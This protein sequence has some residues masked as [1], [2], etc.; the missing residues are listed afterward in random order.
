MTEKGI[1]AL[2]VSLKRG[3]LWI[4]LLLCA[5]SVSAQSGLYLPTDKPVRNM[6]KAL[7]NPEAFHL[8][9]CLRGEETSY[10]EADLDLLDSVYAIAFAVEN[11][12]LYTMSIEGY[13]GDDEQVTQQRMDAVYRYFAMRCHAQFPIRY[14]RNPIRCSCK[15]DTVEVL[16]FEVPVATAAYNYS[17]LPESRRLLNKSIDLKNSVL[18][19]FRNNPDECVGS[20]R[21]CYIPTEDSTVY[22]YYASLLLSKGSV[23][24]VE[25]TKD[26]CPNGLNIKIDDYLDYR[27]IVERYHLIPHR[28]QILAMAG[29]IVVS[30]QW[31]VVSD[32]C[33]EPQKDS[34][35]VRIPVTQEQ[36]DAKLKFFAKVRTSYGLEYKQLPTRKMP[37]KGALALQAPVNITQ[38]DTIYVGKRIQE[39]EVSKYFYEVDS[40]TEAAS[41][42]I[43]NRFY[44]ASRPG[45]DGRPELKKA[46]RQLFRIIPDQ[47]EEDLPSEKMRTPKGEEIIE[48]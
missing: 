45:K 7:V 13:G 3:I 33:T 36:L 16:R 46:L 17:E 21:G 14:A 40:P 18:V 37:G 26:T 27:Y 9:L 19:T 23:Y 1:N 41:F 48:D 5:G 4:L 11:P 47:E 10:S 31:P 20:A 32:S 24:S 15:G 38:L 22:G 8:L 44:V 6:Q 43:G 12:N 42:S 2:N 35:F 28:K 29:Y 34:I 39:K 25:N 30:G